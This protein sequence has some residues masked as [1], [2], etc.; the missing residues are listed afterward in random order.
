M[1]REQM[2]AVSKLLV[3]VDGIQGWACVHEE[4]ASE[5][6]LWGTTIRREDG[7]GKKVHAWIAPVG[8]KDLVMS[9]SINGDGFSS[10]KHVQHLQMEEFDARLAVTHLAAFLSFVSN[11]DGVL[12]ALRMGEGKPSPEKPPLELAQLMAGV[13][14]NVEIFDKVS[15]PFISFNDRTFTLDGPVVQATLFLL[16]KWEEAPETRKML[17]LKE[18]R[19]KLRALIEAAGPEAFKDVEQ[20]WNEEIVASVMGK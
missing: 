11:G 4:R 7:T 9:F 2:L 18:V 5:N 17:A 19:G 6:G 14:R 10:S 3:D 16:R 13:V 8:A 12:D 15:S 1:T 20:V